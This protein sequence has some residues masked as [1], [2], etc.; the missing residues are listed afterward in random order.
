MAHPRDRV[1]KSENKRLAQGGRRIP[2]GI[3]PAEAAEALEK[4]KAAGYA[5]SGAGCIAR[6]IIEAAENI[7]TKD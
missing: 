5:K 7:E 3:L 1:R 6:A 2:G 4:L